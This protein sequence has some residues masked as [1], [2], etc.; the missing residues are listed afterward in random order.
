MG[1][2]P[3]NLFMATAGLF[4]AP[5]KCLFV[6]QD[7]EL[8]I[9]ALLALDQTFSTGPMRQIAGVAIVVE[10]HQPLML[11]SHNE[12]YCCK[13]LFG[14]GTTYII[15]ISA[16]QHA[17]HHLLLMPQPD[18]VRWYLSNTID[19]NTLNLFYMWII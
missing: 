15:T 1:T 16:I 18:S 14:V 12:I 4:P 9:K 13:P 10:R 2:S 17:V 19:L 11:P 6:V 3:D 7:A 8:S 5:L